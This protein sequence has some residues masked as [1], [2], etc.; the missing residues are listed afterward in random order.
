[1]LSLPAAA[2]A[3]LRG[4]ENT[5]GMSSIARR[6]ANQRELKA[7]SP[8]A[9]K[10][11]FFRFCKAAGRGNTGR[12]FCK[13]AGRGNIGRIFCKAAG[14]GNIG[15]VFCK[16]AGRGNIGRISRMATRQNQIIHPFKAHCTLIILS[17]M[18][19]ER[20]PLIIYFI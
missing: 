9:E 18:R 16:A 1:M 10:M 19:G 13:A 11:K 15:R 3:L 20:Q 12:I 2:S 6:A 4:P 8:T 7:K 5:P 14:R 17:K